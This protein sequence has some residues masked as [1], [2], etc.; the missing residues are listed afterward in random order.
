MYW[1]QCVAAA[2]D[3]NGT[4][5]YNISWYNLVVING[6]NTRTGPLTGHDDHTARIIIANRCFPLETI[7]YAAGYIKY[8]YNKTAASS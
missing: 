7:I 4:L 6:R 5:R 8:C 1:V 2:C 3:T